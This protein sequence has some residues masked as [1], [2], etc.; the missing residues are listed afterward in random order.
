M[1]SGIVEFAQFVSELLEIGRKGWYYCTVV[2]VV[3]ANCELATF[4]A[5]ENAEKRERPLA[6]EGE[7]ATVPRQSR[8]FGFPV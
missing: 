1:A 2:L 3:L 7:A 4:R 8:V 5:S 6:N